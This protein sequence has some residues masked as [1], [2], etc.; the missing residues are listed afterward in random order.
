[1]FLAL[2]RKYFWRCP[3]LVACEFQVNKS[4]CS[5]IER[6]GL[7]AQ[8]RFPFEHSSYLRFMQWVSFDFFKS[9]DI[10]S[11][12]KN[13]RSCTPNM[14]RSTHVK[15][16]LRVTGIGR[17]DPYICEKP[18]KSPEL[19]FVVV[20]P[21]CKVNLRL[22][23]TCIELSA[24]DSWKGATVEV[25]RNQRLVNVCCTLGAHKARSI[26]ISA[27]KQRTPGLK[28]SLEQNP[29]ETRKSCSTS[30]KQHWEPWRSFS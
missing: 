8:Q 12:R 24:K 16:R 20:K 1:M 22:T 21:I 29:L 19:T 5:N 6:H 15:L 30:L 10:A 26:V 14:L 17:R 13:V 11:V 28:S 4:L 18:L 2:Y 9:N 25:K 7:I 3:S 27:A 23:F